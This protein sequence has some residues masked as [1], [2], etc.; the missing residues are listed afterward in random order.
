M[1]LT[2]LTAPTAAVATGNQAKEWAG[3]T[4]APALY[5][6]RIATATKLVEAHVGVKLISQRWRLDL[7]AFPDCPWIQLPHGPWQTGDV[8]VGE[9]TFDRTPVVTYYD[10]DGDSTTW[11]EAL[12]QF[13]SIGGRLA[14]AIGEAWPATQS[15]RLNA[16]S[17]SFWCGYG[18]AASA[19]PEL[20]RDAILATVCDWVAQ[21]AL[22]FDLPPGI[23]RLLDTLWGT[24]PV[25]E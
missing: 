23:Q 16:V 11:A 14:P 22:R 15:G 5:E 8:V 2:L 9:D 19:V 18:D 20:A 24:R 1:N 17:V 4:H 10:A 7:D 21:R 25:D 3:G 13:D 6:A 12:W